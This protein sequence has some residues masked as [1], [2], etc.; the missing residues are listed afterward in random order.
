MKKVL[1]L[2]NSFT[3]FYD[4]PALVQ[5]LTCGELICHSIT[6]G[7]A[8]LNAYKTLSDELTVRLI[9]MLNEEQY[10][11]VV[12]Q[13]QSLNAIVNFEDYLSSVKHIKSLVG[14][15]KILIYQTWGYKDGSALLSSTG[16][17]FEE[18]TDK[19]EDASKRAAGQIGGE[20]IPVGRAFADALKSGV[21]IELYDPDS[22][23]P[24]EAGSLL[25]A[26]TFVKF[27]LK[28]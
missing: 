23:H 8:Y 27:L 11:Y 18:M 21:D 22:L 26:K 2:G 15:A 13:E 25:A 12:L 24:S 6:R 3:Y 1:F 14:K 7:G 4:L 16:M 19:L 20:V 28:K 17:S 5:N 9:E 10:D